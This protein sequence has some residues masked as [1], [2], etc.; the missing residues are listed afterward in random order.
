MKP[1]ICA[2]VKWTLAAAGGGPG[3]GRGAGLAGSRS[4]AAT[5][6]MG[7]RRASSLRRT[8]MSGQAMAAMSPGGGVGEEEL[9]LS[10]GVSARAGKRLSERR[11]VSSGSPVAEKPFALLVGAQGGGDLRG[12]AAV[13]VAEVQVAAAEFLLHLAHG[14]VRTRDR[15]RDAQ[16]RRHEQ[17]T[18]RQP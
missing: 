6:R 10:A 9:L 17:P 8:V 15:Q 2:G 12:L 11:V 3:G 18:Q 7:V 4:L 13:D 16:P 14:L 1:C 5:G